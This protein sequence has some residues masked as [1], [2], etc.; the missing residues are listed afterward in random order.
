MTDSSDSTD[1]NKLIAERRARLAT[2]RARGQAFPNGFRR[3]DAVLLQIIRSVARTD[4][5]PF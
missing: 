1:D 2:L 3:D 5:A 4:S